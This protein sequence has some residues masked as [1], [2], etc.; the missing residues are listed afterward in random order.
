MRLNLVSRNRHTS[1]QR[2]GGGHTLQGLMC[3]NYTSRVLG[4][5]EGAYLQD[6]RY[7]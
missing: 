3:S 7:K 5:Q 4:M 1:T 2:G 6:L